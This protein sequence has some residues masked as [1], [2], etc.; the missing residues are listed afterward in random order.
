MKSINY[1]LGHRISTKYELRREE[2]EYLC[3]S[4]VATRQL[5]GKSQKM[6][7]CRVCGE[8]FE[9]NLDSTIR[10]QSKQLLIVFGLLI[11]AAFIPFAIIFLIFAVIA[12]FLPVSKSDG[13]HLISE[14]HSTASHAILYDRK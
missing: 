3:T 2:N 6:C 11:I 9:L 1:R 13:V 14:G 5:I 4:I 7:V 12:L 8:K 10:C